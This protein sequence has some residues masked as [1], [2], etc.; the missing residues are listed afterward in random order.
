MDE[1][2]DLYLEL[3]EKI[4]EWAKSDSVHPLLRICSQIVRDSALE[5]LRGISD[6]K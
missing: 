5:E 1:I 2:T 3:K 4:D 6:D